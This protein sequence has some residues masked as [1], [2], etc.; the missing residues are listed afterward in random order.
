MPFLVSAA[1]LCD[2]T[3]KIGRLSELDIMHA[4]DI[5]DAVNGDWI[6][7]FLVPLICGKGAPCKCLSLWQSNDMISLHV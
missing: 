6:C 2:L 4:N 5:V 3:W 7:S 1:L